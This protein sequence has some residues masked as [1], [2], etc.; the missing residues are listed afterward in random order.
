M[1]QAY[2]R[3]S[4]YSS[5]LEF[6]VFVLLRSQNSDQMELE[7]KRAQAKVQRLKDTLQV[8]N[9]SDHCNTNA[10]LICCQQSGQEQMNS[11]ASRL[12]MV[13]KENQELR[14]QTAVQ[15]SPTHQVQTQ[16]LHS[17][18]LHLL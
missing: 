2:V 16:C 4:H 18:D 11:M 6:E 13:L 5:V 12:S 7:L 14:K 3:V 10:A 17:F 1:F 9:V 15:K 8:L